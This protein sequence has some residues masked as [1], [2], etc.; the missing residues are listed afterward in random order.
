MKFEEIFNEKIHDVINKSQATV[1]KH[2][3]KRISAI[4]SKVNSILNLSE[5]EDEKINRALK[6]EETTRVQAF[7]TV[8]QKAWLKSEALRQDMNVSQLLRVIVEKEIRNKK[9]T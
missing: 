5:N 9:D 3:S 4:E 1:N 7:L 8:K 6:S 2:I